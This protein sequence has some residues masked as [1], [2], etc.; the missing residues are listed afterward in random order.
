MTENLV[1]KSQVTGN[2]LCSSRGWTPDFTNESK[3]IE[4]HSTESELLCA[5]DKNS[6]RLWGFLR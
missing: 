3:V 1:E 6:A 5:R 4:P 2:I